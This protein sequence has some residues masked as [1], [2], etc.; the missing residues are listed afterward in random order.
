MGFY[1]T[2]LESSKPH[3]EVPNCASKTAS[4][5]IFLSNRKF[6]HKIERNPLKTQQGK[7]GYT[8]KTASGRST[9]PSRDPIE[10][11]G[12]LNL[13]AFVE[14][15]GINSWDELGLA[16]IKWADIKL[17]TAIKHY[18]GKSG[19]P[20]EIAFSLVDTKDVTVAEDFEDVEEWLEEHEGT[21]PWSD[22][23]S[24]L[25]NFKDARFVHSPKGAGDAKNVLGQITLK[26]EGLVTIN[27]DCEY[28]VKGTLKSF[29]DNYGFEMQ[30]WSES[31]WRNIKT[32]GGRLIYG[33]GKN[34]EIEIRGS[35]KI[36]ES[37]SI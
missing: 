11:S 34:Y 21:F 30:P 17:A 32:L 15:D 18:N 28:T 19:D 27:C 8:Y 23:D 26:F 14:N 33:A 2:T 7:L 9:W 6:T 25:K 37:G 3:P 1:T 20:V 4:R 35:K 10:E 16:V 24:A 29:D 36:K 13:Y 12:G 22:C 5:E 31:P